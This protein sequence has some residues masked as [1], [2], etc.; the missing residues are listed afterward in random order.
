[1]PRLDAAALAGRLS[2]I[3]RGGGDAA[4]A[5]GGGGSVAANSRLSGPGNCL[6]R[7]LWPGDRPQNPA[8]WIRASKCR[9]NRSAEIW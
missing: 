5:S 1:M 8:S 6:S 3:L 7:L 4:L 9:G 2:E